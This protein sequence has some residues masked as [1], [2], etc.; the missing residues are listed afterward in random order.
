MLGRY[1][2][3]Q[4]NF[5]PKCTIYYNLTF[6]NQTILQLAQTIEEKKLHTL[7]NAQP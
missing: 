4:F 1:K 3:K 7:M 5:K 6:P 2:G